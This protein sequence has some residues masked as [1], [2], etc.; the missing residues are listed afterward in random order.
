MKLNPYSSLLVY[1]ILFLNLCWMSGFQ[2][3]DSARLHEPSILAWIAFLVALGSLAALFFIIYDMVTRRQDQFEGKI[4][5]KEGSVIHIL[6]TEDKL[7]RLR[8]HPNGVRDQLLAN[9]IVEFKLTHF[10]RVPVSIRILKERD[11]QP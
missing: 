4:I 2:I 8:I 5:N 6:T 1:L 3:F 7:K 10:T 11:E 9:Q